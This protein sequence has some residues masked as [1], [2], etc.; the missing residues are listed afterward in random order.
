MAQ[1]HSSSTVT[2]TPPARTL[3]LTEI[4]YAG[5]RWHLREPLVVHQTCEDD[6]WIW[7]NEEYHVLG[8]GDDLADV[9]LD[10]GFAFSVQWDDIA[11]AEADILA[12]DARRVREGLLALV[13]DC[14]MTTSDGVPSRR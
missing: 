5:R 14:G 2:E 4:A 13:I 10:F 6:V 11:C 12:P 1:R 9:A 3:S 8:H 7:E